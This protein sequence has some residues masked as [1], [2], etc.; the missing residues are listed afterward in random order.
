MRMEPD[1]SGV[2]RWLREWRE[3]GADE[4]EAVLGD[5]LVES[6]LDVV[7]AVCEA[8]DGEGEHA[9]ANLEMAA[10]TL[11]RDAAT[12]LALSE[13]LRLRACIDVRDS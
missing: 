7:E 5:G 8:V 3:E 4:L 2:A 11:E 13:L 6:L 10:T 1:A 9:A 12:A